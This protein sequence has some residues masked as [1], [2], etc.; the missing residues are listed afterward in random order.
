MLD[1]FHL[2][3]ILVIALILLG[4]EELAVILRA[5][6]KLFGQLRRMSREFYEYVEN[7]DPKKPPRDG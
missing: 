7:L 5:C 1:G 4:P 3:L 6:G 2:I